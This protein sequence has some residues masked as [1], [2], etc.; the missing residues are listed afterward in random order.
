MI[1]LKSDLFSF[2]LKILLS[3]LVA[4]SA[5]DLCLS[6]IYVADYGLFNDHFYPAYGFVEL[7]STILYIVIAII[8]LIWIYRVH[9]DLNRLYL[10]YPRTPAEA[11]LGMIIPLYNLYGIPSTFMRI[12]SRYQST[13]ALRRAG[14]WI[15]GLAVPLVLLTLV[16]GFTN[17]AVAGADD[18][19]GTLLF[20]SSLI[21]FAV[22]VIYL[23]LA[24][25]VSRGLHY[26]HARI[27]DEPGA[28]TFDAEPSERPELPFPVKS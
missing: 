26:T 22:Y 9:M 21:S 2:V 25:L 20:A 23:A 10:R 24:L 1:A 27:E 14:G 28:M 18:V 17:Q 6:M 19:S 13:P 11:L 16:S 4:L 5:G 8:F 15:S 12:G 3:A 7:I